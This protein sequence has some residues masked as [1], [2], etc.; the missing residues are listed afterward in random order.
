MADLC[1]AVQSAP[2]RVGNGG[3]E[4]DAGEPQTANQLRLL[5]ATARW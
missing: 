4:R 2:L 5:L 1:P 3:D